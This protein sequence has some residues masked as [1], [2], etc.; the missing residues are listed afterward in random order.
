M[1]IAWL[2]AVIDL[3]ADGFS[4]ALEFWVAVSNSTPGEIHPDHPEFIHLLPAT[5]AMH[6]E[7]QRIDEGPAGAHLDLLVDDIAAWTERAVG[8]GASIVDQPGHAVLATPG[9]VRFCIVPHGDEAEPAPPIDPAMPHAIDQLCLD[10]PHD[11]FEA[12]VAFWAA[13]S[14]WEPAGSTSYPEFR[15]F[16]QAATLPIR[17]LIQRLGADD[18]GPARAHLDIS[19]GDHVEAVVARH[20]DLG[21]R[22]VRR[23]ERWTALADPAGQLYCVTRTTPRNA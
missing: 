5:G 21:A 23:H 2:Q 18:P 16:D 8:L 12:D 13:L 4:E 10:V 9:G 15:W 6:L 20:V 17:L 22:V 19:A 7:V 14:G 1:E 3:P 11:H